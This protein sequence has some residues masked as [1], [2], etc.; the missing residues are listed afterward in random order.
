M[1]TII[2]GNMHR[3]VRAGV[4]GTALIGSVVVG[5][6]PSVA[7]L[8]IEQTASIQFQ[9]R[10]TDVVP[11]GEG[12]CDYISTVRVRGRTDDG[13]AVRGNRLPM[14]AVAPCDDGLRA[15]VDIRGTGDVDIVGR[16]GGPTS[17]I[18]IERATGFVTF[19]AESSLFTAPATLGPVERNFP[20]DGDLLGRIDKATPLGAGIVEYTVSARV[21]GST[22]DGYRLRPTRFEEIKVTVTATDDPATGW[23]VEEG[24]G[25]VATISGEAT[26]TTTGRWIEVLSFSGEIAFLVAGTDGPPI[27][28]FATFG[29]ETSL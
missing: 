25:I 16:A 6:G 24:L 14:T 15:G 19:G 7:A 4:V 27:T 21:S 9:G 13:R 22:D 23:K 29:H 11:D 1:V 17:P 28:G 2:S 12:S 10:L 18:R 5:H 8:E 26:G 3:T 20:L